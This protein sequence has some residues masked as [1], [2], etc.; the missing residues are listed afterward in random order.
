MPGQETMK[1]K[2]GDSVRVDS[3]GLASHIAADRLS[4]CILAI[5]LEVNKAV[6]AGTVVTKR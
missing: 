1:T 4:A 2:L 3:K 6:R 5:L